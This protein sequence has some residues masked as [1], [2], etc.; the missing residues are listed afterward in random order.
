[1]KRVL[2]VGTFDILHPGHVLYLREARK[3]AGKNGELW[4]IV[5]SD[6]PARGKPK[7]SRPILPAEFRAAI[8]RELKTV[9]RVVVGSP[10][11]IFEL[12]PRIRP[13]ILALG[14]NQPYDEKKLSR[15]L[16][17]LGLKT[18]VVRIRKFYRGK[19]GSSTKIRRALGI[20]SITS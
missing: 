16:G 3:L 2:A 14:A 11:D 18:R 4:V 8:V 13:D 17:A 10:R 19:F 15:K 6:S 12:L 7:K 5:A 1:V 20:T 9:D